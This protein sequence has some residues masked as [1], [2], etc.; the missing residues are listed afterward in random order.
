MTKFKTIVT[1]ALGALCA[2]TACAAIALSDGG[3]KFSVDAAGTHSTEIS[4][5][6]FDSTSFVFESSTEA[7]GGIS[8]T[9]TDGAGLSLGG[10]TGIAIRVKN[11]SGAEYNINQIRVYIDGSPIIYSPYNSENTF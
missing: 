3:E 11:L 2:L 5:T 10:K 6:D 8:Y 4:M 1:S 9:F 7:A